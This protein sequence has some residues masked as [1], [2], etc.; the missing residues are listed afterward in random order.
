MAGVPRQRDGVRAEDRVS[1]MSDYSSQDGEEL[2]FEEAWSTVG[3]S[4]GSISPWESGPSPTTSY[5]ASDEANSADGRPEGEGGSH[6][7]RLHL[8]NMTAFPCPEVEYSASACR[9]RFGLESKEFLG[10]KSKTYYAE[11][12]LAPEYLDL[13][14]EMRRLPQQPN[15]EVRVC[16]ILR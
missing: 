4:G 16:R 14:V 11:S 5:S 12:T 15:L 2:A 13:R 10:Q 6:R 3:S 7:E 8:R 1:V 9:E